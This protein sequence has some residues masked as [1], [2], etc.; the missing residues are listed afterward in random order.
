MASDL[1]KNWVTFDQEGVEEKRSGHP[2][3][4]PWP[5][6]GISSTEFFSRSLSSDSSSFS[7]M[8]TSSFESRGSSP[9]HNSEEGSKYS[10]F[11]A[12]QN[13]APTDRDDNDISESSASCSMDS[14]YSVFSSLREC[15]EKGEYLG[16]S[17]KVLGEAMGWSETLKARPSF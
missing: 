2:T 4:D 12:L 7:S 8:S 11:K 3:S 13:P 10:A 1:A 5:I 16:W 17:K 15:E 9:T 6:S 14:K